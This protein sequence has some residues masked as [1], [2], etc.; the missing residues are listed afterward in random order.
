MESPPW[1]FD[2]I[3]HAGSEHLDP[4]YVATYDSKAQTDP[5]DD[6]GLLCQ[7]GM[8]QRSTV[9]DFGAGTGTFTLAAARVCL[10]VVAVDV[11]AV[12]LE[13]L[14]S[15]ASRLGLAN[16]EC[17]QSGFLTY[18]HQGE[19]GGFRLLTEC[20]ASPSGL[21]ESSCLAACGRSTSHRRGLV[22]PRSRLLVQSQGG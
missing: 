11:S 21:L 22:P 19:L 15:S 12:M 18:E 10:R 17:V 20:I 2:E 1:L 7:F 6:L 3:S 8:D 14:R 9:V 13:R 5:S 4:T 16:V